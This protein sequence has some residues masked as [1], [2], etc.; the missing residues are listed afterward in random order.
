MRKKSISCLFDNLM[1]YLLY[2]LPLFLLL[3]YLVRTGTVVDL[4]TIFSDFGLDIL[5]N[6]QIL[7][8][9]SSLFGS[10][11][12]VPLFASES[13]LVYFSYFISVFVVHLAV[14]FLLFIP[15]LAHKWL[16]KL[17]GS[18]E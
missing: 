15:R 9:L 13:I 16:N 14:D 1:W 10:S 7:V 12:V 2:L 8:A 6:N 18:E 4:S 3:I 5:T 11:G 17:W